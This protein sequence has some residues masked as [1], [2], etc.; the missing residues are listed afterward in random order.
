[1]VGHLVSPWRAQHPKLPSP[2]HTRPDSLQ[3]HTLVHSFS[4]KTYFEDFEYG[5]IWRPYGSSCTRQEWT[6]AGSWCLSVQYLLQYPPSMQISPTQ[7]FD[8]DYEKDMVSLETGEGLTHIWDNLWHPIRSYCT[9]RDDECLPVLG[10]DLDIVMPYP[11]K[12]T[13][14]M[15]TSGAQL[16]C[17]WGQT[18]HGPTSVV[19]SNGCFQKLPWCKTLKHL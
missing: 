5:L 3:T 6:A 2:I 11:E 7:H 13:A 19:I 1:M 8:L 14:K 18:W 12:L 9:V 17:R 15:K 4:F 16:A 10:E